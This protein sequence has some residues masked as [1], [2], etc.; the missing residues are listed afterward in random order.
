MSRGG[1]QSIPRPEQWRA[2]QS[3][4]WLGRTD[5]AHEIEVPRLVSLGEPPHADPPEPPVA[6]PTGWR[7]AAVLVPFHL[8]PVAPEPEVLLVRRRDDAPTHSGEVAFPGGVRAGGETL[9]DTALREAEE[10]AGV[11]PGS[12]QL[13]SRLPVAQTFASRFWIT[14][15]VA[16]IDDVA[17]LHPQETE[18]ER[19]LRVPVAELLDAR[20]YRAETWEYGDVAVTMSFFEIEGETIWGFTARVLRRILDDLLVPG[21]PGTDPA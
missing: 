13:R 10:E 4:G 19:I 2:A 21:G 16:T 20:T 18:I 6:V 1:R 7:E 14:P 12:V 11:S 3:P 8:P 9:A 17:G 15:F 5:R